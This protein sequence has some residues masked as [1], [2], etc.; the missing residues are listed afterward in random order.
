[1]KSFD[2]Y[3]S[4]KDQGVPDSYIS[5]TDFFMNPEYALP[6]YSKE[7]W[8]LGFKTFDEMR[9]KTFRNAKRLFLKTAA[10]SFASFWNGNIDALNESQI[11]EFSKLSSFRDLCGFMIAFETI[12]TSVIN[13]RNNRYISFGISKS[14]YNI[15][16]Y[17]L[18]LSIKRGE[19]ATKFNL[20][21]SHKRRLNDLYMAPKV[22]IYFDGEKRRDQYSVTVDKIDLYHQFEFW[23]RTNGKTR[24]Q[25]IY[26]AIQV[27]LKQCPLGP[28]KG[29][30]SNVSVDE[31]SS[32]TYVINSRE[33][34]K[35]SASINIPASIYDDANKI[36]RRYNNDPQNV[37]KDK[38]NFSMYVAQAVAAFNK[39]VPLKYSDPI[40][41]QNYLEIKEAEQ[42]NNKILG[43]EVNEDAE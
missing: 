4:E 30:N 5:L 40:A 24:K 39:R 20:S 23:C 38:L 27:L 8:A 17:T 3:L 33:T 42:Y 34:G 41:Y 11:N 18:E 22:A 13:K 35:Q 36:I 9:K 26:E 1:M 21:D 25:G 29:E 19:V 15:Y 2:F 32:L 28:N 6:G 14:N 16:K 31:I 12:K 43:K 37:T 7:E 10:N